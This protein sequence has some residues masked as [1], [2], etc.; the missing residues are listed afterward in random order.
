MGVRLVPKR[1]GGSAKARCSPVSHSNASH[2]TYHQIPTRFGSHNVSRLATKAIHFKASFDSLQTA[3]THATQPP[4]LV[5]TRHLSLSLS[6]PA[7]LR[8]RL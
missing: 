5:T 4:S 7:P 1:E 2:I 6:A 3:Q 8:D